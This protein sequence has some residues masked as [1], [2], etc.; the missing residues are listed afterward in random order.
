MR[1]VR[2]QPD[3]T[4]SVRPLKIGGVPGH[5]IRA[6]PPRGDRHAPPRIERDPQ[7]VAAFVED[8]AH[9]PGGHARGVAAP[10]SE[11][12]VAALLR[13]TTGSVLPIGAQSSLTGGAT[14]TGDLVLS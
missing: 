9:Y 8:A 1:G 11:A 14:P 2:L 3:S 13:S 4:V 12:E 10:A 5:S 7:V 6:R